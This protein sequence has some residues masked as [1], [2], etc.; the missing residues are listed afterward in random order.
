MDG[1]TAAVPLIFG[2]FGDGPTALFLADNDEDLLGLNNVVDESN[3]APS[4]GLGIGINLECCQLYADVA[5]AIKDMTS[6]GTLERSRK[7]DN[8][9]L[10][11]PEDLTPVQ[12]RGFESNIDSNAIAN[13]VFSKYCPCPLTFVLN[14]TT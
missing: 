10:F 11:D 13:F 4:Q 1:L 5:Q 2:I 8:V 6:D 7:Q 12:C 14:G 3:T 9:G